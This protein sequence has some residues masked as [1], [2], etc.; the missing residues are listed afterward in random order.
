L[1]VSSVFGL[2]PVTGLDSSACLLPPIPSHRLVTCTRPVLSRIRVGPLANRIA[3]WNGTT[4]SSLGSGMNNV[5][6][7]VAVL[8][9]DVYAGGWFTM[10]GGRSAYRLAKWNGAIWS[11]AGLTASGNDLYVGGWFEWAGGIPASH[12]AKWN[13]SSWSALCSGAWG[14]VSTFAVSGSNV[15]AGGSPKE[16]KRR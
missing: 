11:G 7:A 10:A 12:I 3:K 16:Q 5:V 4:W 15:Y 1:V 13:G 2:R 6:N 8:G 9:N 14:I